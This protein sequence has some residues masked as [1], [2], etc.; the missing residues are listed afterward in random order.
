M[1]FTGNK[2][3]VKAVKTPVDGNAE[4]LGFPIRGLCG[5]LQHFTGAVLMASRVLHLLVRGGGCTPQEE[6]KA[7]FPF[8]KCSC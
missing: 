3:Y 4:A 1:L 8:L 5:M 6:E 2:W 7:A